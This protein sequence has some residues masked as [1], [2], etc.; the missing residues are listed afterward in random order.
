MFVI[1]TVTKVYDL[2]FQMNWNRIW[3]GTLQTILMMRKR[4]KNQFSLFN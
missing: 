3:L 1:D 2:S 4:I